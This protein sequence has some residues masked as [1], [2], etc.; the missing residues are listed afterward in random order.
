MADAAGQRGYWPTQLLAR[1]NFQYGS[2]QSSDVLY[3]ELN[4]HSLL[5]RMHKAVSKT[6][7]QVDKQVELQA[8]WRLPHS[9]EDFLGLCG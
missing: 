3:H 7:K 5:S 6:Q 9:L 2:L 1:E 8:A 4:K